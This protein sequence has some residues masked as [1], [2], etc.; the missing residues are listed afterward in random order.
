MKEEEEEEEEETYFGNF[1]GRS[2]WVNECAL[3]SDLRQES[4][5]AESN[6]IAAVFVNGCHWREENL[7]Q[8]SCKSTIHYKYTFWFQLNMFTLW[9]EYSG[10][11]GRG[12]QV[13][14]EDLSQRTRLFW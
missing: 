1:V 9:R 10:P 7:G 4:L 14:H 3:S 8:N 2:Q 6:K 11:D 5:A 12:S 13:E